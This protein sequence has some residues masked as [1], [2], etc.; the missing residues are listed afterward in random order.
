M[1]LLDSVIETGKAVYR[2]AGKAIGFKPQPNTV[3]EIT[4]VAPDI[5][6]HGKGGERMDA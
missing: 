5:N 3:R 2:E 6:P 1:L 4:P